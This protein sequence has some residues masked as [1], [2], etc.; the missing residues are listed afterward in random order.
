MKDGKPVMLARVAS[1]E[2]QSYYAGDGLNTAHILPA[3]MVRVLEESKNN[4]K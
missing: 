1:F 3:D 4:G 2:G